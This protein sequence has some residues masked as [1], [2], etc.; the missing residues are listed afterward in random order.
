MLSR[1]FRLTSKGDFKDVF[2]GGSAHGGTYFILTK[3]EVDQDN[4]TFGVIVSNKVSKRASARNRI[5]RIVRE[6]I[7]K[8]ALDLSGQY[9]VVAKKQAEG[10]DK[11]MLR[12][13]LVSLFSKFSR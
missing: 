9:V 3:K 8:E 11:L 1:K 6:Y 13:D 12:E 4:P 10:A 2:S 5:K 7:Q